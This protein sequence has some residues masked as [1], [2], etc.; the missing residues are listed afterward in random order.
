MFGILLATMLLFSG[1]VY[2]DSIDGLWQH[3]ADYEYFGD[4]SLIKPMA[5]PKIQIVGGNLALSATCVAKMKV[6]QY[7]PS[8]VFQSI[9]RQKVKVLEIQKYFKDKLS[10]PIENIDVV[11]KVEKTDCA[12]TFDRILVV[13]NQMI[14]VHQG[15]TFYKFKRV[16]AK[17]PV[18]SASK[19][20]LRQNLTPLPFNLPN[21]TNLCEPLI[22]RKRGV[23]QSS[24]KCAP[25]FYPYA[26]VKGDGDRISLLVGKHLYSSFGKDAT[27]DYDDPHSKGL[28][29]V[30]IVLPPMNDVVLVRVDDLEPAGEKRDAFSGAYLSIKGDHVID[31]LNEGCSMDVNYVCVDREGKKIS[32]VLPSGKFSLN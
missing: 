14:V 12:K 1:C 2:A 29:P 25:N 11:Y 23:P 10:V 16:D 26:S 7:M 20:R 9:I 22:E 4:N 19:M 27:S 17:I 24:T 31:Q 6:E 13:G 5:Y 15:S 30:Y 3:T 28:T 21:Y 32:R 8:L 18:A